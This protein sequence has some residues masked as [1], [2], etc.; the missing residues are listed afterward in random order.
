MAYLTQ[1]P[2]TAEFYPSRLIIVFVQDN[3]TKEYF[4][5]L[6]PGLGI[7]DVHITTFSK[8]AFEVLGLS[9]YEY[10]ERYGESEEEK[11]L[12]EYQ[13]IQALREKPTSKW[14]KNI[15]AVLLSQYSEYFSAKNKILFSGQKQHKILDRFD[16]TILLKAYFE[17]YK[18]FEIKTQYNT[19]VKD[20][21]VRKTRKTPV[22]YSLMIVDEFQNYLPEQ[23]QVFKHCLNVDTESAIYVGDMA[24]QVKLGT[25]KNWE[26]IGEHILPERNIRL[27]KVYRNTKNILSFI[28]SLG[29][30]VDVP[31]GVKEG[32]EVF[33]KITNTTEAEIAHI[34]EHIPTYKQGSI[35]IISKDETHLEPFRKEFVQAKNIHVLTMLESQGV[36]FDIVFIVGIKKES[37]NITHHNDVL[38]KHIEERK[39]MQKDLLYVALTRA[40]TELH[41][42][43]REKLST[44]LIENDK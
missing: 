23:L 22:L 17:K 16:L 25:I 26:D 14:N 35:G 43:G 40:I 7:Y 41:I 42:L 18:K 33:E 6:L 34:Q 13:K 20:T 29:Y 38:P 8:W 30:S 24:Q 27:N 36:E 12:Y 21:L 3:G 9:G 32:P 4:S 1:A 5:T 44:I 28:Q 31:I 37:F 15:F 10:F 2:D 11:D 39:R 19:F